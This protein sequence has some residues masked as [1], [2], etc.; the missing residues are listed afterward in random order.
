MDKQKAIEMLGGTPKL[1]AEA[2]GYTSVHAVYMWPDVLR[3]SVAN[4]VRGIVASMD[5]KPKRK[6]DKATA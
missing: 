4:Q 6:T 2:M 5:V 1:A 3:P